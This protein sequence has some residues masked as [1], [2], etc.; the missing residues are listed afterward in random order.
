MK[1]DAKTIPNISAALEAGARNPPRRPHEVPSMRRGIAGMREILFALRYASYRR[2][3]SDISTNHYPTLLP[4]TGV[5]GQESTSDP[6]Q[7]EVFP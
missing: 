6:E 3:S 5:P 4:S 7:D 2:H 1:E